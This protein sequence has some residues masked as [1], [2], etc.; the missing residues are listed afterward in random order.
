MFKKLGNSIKKTI[1]DPVRLIT[2]P[3]ETMV[4]DPIKVGAAKASEFANSGAVQDT[5][6]EV[7]T[8]ANTP[9]GGGLLANFGVPAGLFN[10]PQT[11]PPHEYQPSGTVTMQG[12]QEDN[13]IFYVAGGV[14]VLVLFVVIIKKK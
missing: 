4:L 9:L 12:K 1:K 13:M 7:Q 8:F 10:A 14:L 5:L 6:G 3:V 11:L 2:K